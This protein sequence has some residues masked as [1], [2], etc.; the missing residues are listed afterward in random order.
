M[1]KAAMDNDSVE[2][3]FNNLC[4]HAPNNNIDLDC[5]STETENSE[6]QPSNSNV[7]TSI[8]NQTYA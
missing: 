8:P 7:H 5:L 3:Y 1:K 6:N 2:C 4:T